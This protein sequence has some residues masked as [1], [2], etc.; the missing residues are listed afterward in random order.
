[1]H[2]Q[3]A[4]DPLVLKT[5][6]LFIITELLVV[7]SEAKT[8]GTPYCPDLPVPLIVRLNDALALLVITRRK[9]KSLTRYRYENPANALEYITALAELAILWS[10][11]YGNPVTETD[12]GDSTEPALRSSPLISAES[13][14]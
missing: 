7:S 3:S 14:L 4:V 6:K 9:S 12:T 5:C 13:R 10:S 11:L 2:L 8:N 1:M